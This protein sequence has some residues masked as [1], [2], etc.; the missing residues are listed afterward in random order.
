MSDSIE[1]FVVSYGII[2]VLGKGLGNR[3]R[4]EL[5]LNTVKFRG[6]KLFCGKK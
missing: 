1:Q 5:S 4:Q 2:C 6:G 3:S